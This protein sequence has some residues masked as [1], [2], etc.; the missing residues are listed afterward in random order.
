[1]NSPRKTG[2]GLTP[3]QREA[4]TAFKPATAPLTD[5]QQS[6]KEFEDNRE[7]LK[8]LRLKRDA[9]IKNMK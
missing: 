8:A 5:D 6:K 3:A 1:M 2:A 9:G 7:R 4:E